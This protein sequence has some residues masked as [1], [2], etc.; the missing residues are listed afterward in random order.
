MSS[1]EPPL[2]PGICV[3]PRRT[4][5]G[6]PGKRPGRS[7]PG[8]SSPGMGNGLPPPMA[9]P[10]PPPPPEGRGRSFHW[11]DLLLPVFVPVAGS[12]ATSTSSPGNCNGLPPA[13]MF[14]PGTPR[15]RG[16]NVF[17][18]SLCRPPASMLATTGN[19]FFR[20][21]SSNPD[22]RAARAAMARL[23]SLS[24]SRTLRT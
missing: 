11:P 10:M 13:D 19:I 24:P 17:S 7:R 6:K 5:S 8:M 18:V 20:T 15:K 23:A 3:P 9:P 1:S 4:T 16:A 12:G 22:D 2:G 21:S 14:R